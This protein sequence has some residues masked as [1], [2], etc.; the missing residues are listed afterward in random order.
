MTPDSIPPILQSSPKA[1]YLAR[2]AEIDAAVARTLASGWYILGAEVAAF[3]NE[4]AAYLG[5][6]HAVGVASGTDGL[7]LALRAL[8]IGPGDLVFTAS[9]TAVATVAAIDMCGATP[10]Y[11]D[12]DPATFTMA[13][14]QLEQ[15]IAQA[16]A[17]VPKAVLPV[18]LYGHP[19]DLTAIAGICERHHLRLIEDC[20]QAHGARWAGRKV[21][22]WGDIAVFSCYPTKNLG[23]LGD[24]GIVVTHHPELDA[25]LRLLREYGWRER[26]VS[27]VPGENSRLDE[28]QAAILRVKLNGLDADNL[29][30]G[31]AAA[32]YNHLLA[33]LELTLP[34]VRGEAVS[35]FH[36]YVIRVKQRDALREFLKSQGIGTLVHYPV[37]VHQQPAYAHFARGPL[38]QTEAAARE[39]LS[40][41]LYPEIPDA[42]LCRTASAIRAFF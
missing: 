41:P 12:I 42:D 20:S 25:R 30:R 9:H 13:P 34:T 18:H 11:V 40:L 38:P 36:Q 8:D 17:G 5:T 15:A 28:L 24:A 23:A 16:P 19:A 4:F 22:S 37:P 10:V 31:Q 1:G 33:G 29:R 27:A 7:R 35:V 2:Q 14:N 21:G 39:V 26:Y 3:E 6:N 32:R